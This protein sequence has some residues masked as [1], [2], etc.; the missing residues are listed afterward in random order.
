MTSLETQVVVEKEVVK[1]VC[2][3]M[4]WVGMRGGG[5]RD[6]DVSLNIGFSTSALS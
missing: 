2:E 6:I 5:M 4:G 3:A 1:E